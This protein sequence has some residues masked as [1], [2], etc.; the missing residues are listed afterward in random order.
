MKK[1]FNKKTAPC[2]LAF[3]LPIIIMGTYY[4]IRQMSPFGH[5][6]ILTVDLGQQYVDMFSA[7]RDAILHHPST[8]FYSFSN[9]LGGDMLGVWTYY[10]MSP[11]NLVL[12]FFT[13]VHLASGILLLTLLKYGLAGFS[14]AYA[15][16]KMQWQQGWLL[17]VFGVAYALMG[18]MVAY[19]LNLLWLD[20][21][22]ILPLLIVGL[23]HLIDQGTYRSYIFWLTAIL[24]I[25]YYLAYMIAIFLVLYFVWR[26]T[27]EAF[28]WPERLEKV[29]RF[30]LASLASAGLAAVT[31]LPTA[32]ALTQGK[33]QYMTEHITKIVEYNPLFFFSKMFTG[34]FNFEQM[35]TGQPNIFVA[36]IALIGALIFFTDGRVRLSTKIGASLVTLFLFVS[37]FLAPLDL[38]WHGMQ[39]PV[40]YPYRFSFLWS[41]WLIW[42]AASTFRPGYYINR[43]QII[44][45]C[46][47]LVVVLAIVLSTM[48]KTNFMTWPQVLVGAAFFLLTLSL[49]LLPRFKYWS[50]LLLLLV[51]AETAT[52]AAWDLNNFSFLTQTEYR[53]NVQATQSALQEI[54]NDKPAF[55]R[56]GQTYERTKDDAFMQD[57]FGGAAFSSSFSKQMSDFMG[58]FG[59]PD[60]DNYAVYA[61]GTLLSDNLLG[62]RYYL[63]AA[64]HVS[65]D[66]GAPANMLISQRP[67]LSSMQALTETPD[68]SLYQNNDALGLAFAANSAALSVQ[69]KRDDPLTNQERLWNGITGNTANP[70][71][72]VQNFDKVTTKNADVPQ[73]VTGAFIT[74][75][76]PLEATSL[77]LYFTP[78]TNNSY[79]LTLGASMIPDDVTIKLNDQIMHTNDSFRHT[80]ILNVGDHIK[81]KTQK[82]TFIL[83]KPNL[84][85]QNVS[86]YE[87]DN[88]QIHYQAQALAANN[89]HIHSFSQRKISG[90]VTIP[91]DKDLLMTTI[92]Q[93]QG[94]HV[95]VDGHAAETN[96][97]GKTFL[98]VLMAPGKHHVTFSYTPP[99][100]TLGVMIT[101]VTSLLLFWLFWFRQR[102]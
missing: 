17:T 9:A 23:E 88:A 35:P 52:N 34:S 38:F 85:L 14:M 22:I 64:G 26:L 80:I 18:W 25:N 73:T 7:Y 37:M 56:V 28:T 100:F 51:T 95:T 60:G 54:P 89:L 49:I 55:Y 50:W 84:W 40:W 33:G 67:D 99:Y 72:N 97:V 69:F 82:L 57:Y 3:L 59:N 98:A 68:V 75:K 102:K 31:L 8:F 92:P 47:T 42:L 77:N 65:P 32:Y 78:K 81:G 29:K 27:W 58:N 11:L 91:A 63:D 36:S 53:R 21:V 24:I 90:T 10:L 43:K 70:I 41:F 76:K 13:P 46:S 87:Q 20:A 79:Y 19:E 30:T 5:S 12:L 6:S 15:L 74:R 96:T 94:W 16:H 62:M 48:R 2:W 44:I 86:L 45:I 61:N 93:G 83:K 66:D 4:A 1:L 101:A 39:F 71:F